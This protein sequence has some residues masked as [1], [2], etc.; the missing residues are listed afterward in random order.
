[1]AEISLMPLVNNTHNQGED[2]GGKSANSDYNHSDRAAT[3]ISFTGSFYLGDQ[4]G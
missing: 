4:R 3:S 1:M 2:K